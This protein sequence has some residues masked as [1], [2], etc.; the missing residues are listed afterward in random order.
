VIA[1]DKKILAN[2]TL[3]LRA[4]E[5]GDVTYTDITDGMTPAVE[6]LVEQNIKLDNKLTKAKEDNDDLHKEIT[7]FKQKTAKE[8]ASMRLNVESLEEKLQETQ[9]AHQDALEE[10]AELRRQE[11]STSRAP[12][13]NNSELVAAQ[14][15]IATLTK[16]RDEFK[17]STTRMRRLKREAEHTQDQQQQKLTE[18]RQWFNEQQRRMSIVQ[19]GAPH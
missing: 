14:A 10:L 18:N 15:V 16:D 7:Q 19:I 6:P 11:Q 8:K 3:S 13:R 2:R 4:D 5:D 9:Q 1:Q 12:Y 17:E